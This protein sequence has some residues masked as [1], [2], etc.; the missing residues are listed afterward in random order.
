M[1]VRT[2]GNLKKLAETASFSREFWQAVI[3]ILILSYIS[4][5]II[6][7]LYFS[8]LAPFPGPKLWAVSSI[9]YQ[10]SI[11]RGRSHR[12]VLALHDYYGSVVRVGP[13]ELSFNNA[14][15]FRDI[16]G[17]RP[18][19][20]QLPKDPKLYASKMN[21]VRDSIGG[22]LDNEA[23]TRQ[24][25]LLSHAFSERCLREQEEAIVQYVDLL[26]RRLRDRTK[27]DPKHE[28]TEDLKNWFT[29]VTFDITGD[30]MFAET[31]DC[32]RDGKLHPWIALIFATMKGI[33]F[34][35]VINHFSLIRVLQK[36]ALPESLR[37]K[38]M[39]HF[40]DT[41]Q[42][43]DRRLQKGATRPDL[44]SAILKNGLGDSQG[45]FVENQPI[46]SRREIHANS[47]FITVAGS[48]TSA[49]I[50][51]GC[52]Y[53]LCKYPDAM[54]RICKEVRA[55][56]SRDDEITSAKCGRLPY[57]NAV[58][59]ESLRLYPPLVTSLPRLIPKGGDIVDGY[60]L[61]EDTTVSTHHYA[62]YHAAANF[63][64]PEQFAPE[65]WLN[66][67]RFSSD[68]LEVLHPFSLGPR[69]CL[70]K[71]SVNPIAVNSTY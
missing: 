70:G 18:G 31:F 2:V 61:P 50:L 38:M 17:F 34:L 66:D 29:F 24:R 51:S 43:A 23:H 11:L 14:Q 44:M 27:L 25:R 47:V 71:K 37:E 3:F 48:E 33:T 68:K 1:S 15:A 53:Y 46:M 65:R 5:T 10:I 19:R 69:N 49:S 26:I 12:K 28:A 60:L 59:E 4:Y 63:V 57:L 64:F 13:D 58:I 9:P 52:V 35:S 42:K 8:P 67:S 62:S 36:W 20:P 54:E 45:K 30:L 32:L 56:F 6:Y 39:Q 16:Y 7:S 41:T 22:Y 40:N 21:G 55:A